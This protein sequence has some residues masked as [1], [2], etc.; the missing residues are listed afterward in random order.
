MAQPYLKRGDSGNDV[1]VLQAMLQSQ[2][3]FNAVIGGNFL[4]KTEQAV[5]YFQQTHLGPDGRPLE[6]DGKV[7]PNTW[8]A[9]ANPAGAPQKSNLPREN[10][11]GLTPLRRAVLKA[12]AK[13]HQAGTAESPDGSNWGDGV[14]KFLQAAGA[15]A[16]P[17]CCYFWSW[18]VHQAT[19]QHVFGQPL[20]RVEAA[21]KKAKLNGTA[22]SVNDYSP[23]PGDAFV[24]LYRNRSGKLTGTGH[25]GFVMRVDKR[26]GAT[27]FN[28][29]EGN[30][31]NRVKIGTRQMNQSTLVGFINHYP[32]EEQ[33]TDWEVGLVSAGNV[34]ALGTR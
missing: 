9:L 19:G 28:T 27:A 8:W 7:G 6:V 10:A 17:W 11:T 2:G 22:R 4:A 12:A 5:I 31:A 18:C 1:K 33:P 24:M 16:A 14:T 21:W 30:C 26:K 13:E 20:G 29:I 3:Y 23:I 34:A 15:P 25:I 32:P